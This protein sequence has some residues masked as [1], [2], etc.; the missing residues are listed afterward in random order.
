M[1]PPDWWIRELHAFDP[2]LRTVW[3]PAMQLWQIERRVRRAIHPG[4]IKTDSWDDDYRRA[5]EGFLHVAS[6]PPRGFS[7]YAL[8]KL[9][10]ADLWVDGG[11][12]RIERELCE[13]EAALEA[14]QWKDFEGDLHHMHRE[15]YRFMAARS[16]RLVFS[17]G[18]PGITKEAA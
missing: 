3:S 5:R 15:V 16:G 13:A 6:I 17:A 10:A 8:E 2:D 12:Q 7:R 9:K 18:F 11:W 1:K 14:K 4:T